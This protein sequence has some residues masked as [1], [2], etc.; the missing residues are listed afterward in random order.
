MNK[1]PV[2]EYKTFINRA[3][4]ITSNQVYPLSIAERNQP[5]DIYTDDPEQVTAVLFWHFCEFN[6]V[7]W[8]EDKL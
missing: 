1:V 3:R 4:T 7:I 5:G 8:K 6:A 2:S